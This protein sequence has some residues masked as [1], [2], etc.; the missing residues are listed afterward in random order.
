MEPHAGVLKNPGLSPAISPTACPPITGPQDLLGEV[1]DGVRPKCEVRGPLAFHSPWG[2]QVDGGMV[3]VYAVMRGHCLLDIDHRKFPVDLVSGDL[4]LVA[5]QHAHRLYDRIT[6]PVIPFEQAVNQAGMTEPGLPNLNGNS[7]LLLSM[8]FFYDPLHSHPVVSWLPPVI[9]LKGE[10]GDLPSCLGDVLRAILHEVSAPRPGTQTIVNQLA[11]VLFVQ[12]LRTCVSSLA[13]N[14]NNGL[15]ALLDPEIG[16]ALRLMHQ[17]P[18]RP[19][20]VATIAEEVGM[21]RSVF[22]ARFHA[23]VGRPPLH[24]L[25]QYRMKQ[26]CRLL[27]DPQK[28]L[29]EIAARIGYGSEAAFSNAFKRWAGTAPG[30]Y[31]FSQR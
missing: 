31:R 23:L 12:I 18:G 6:S 22:A 2:I 17:H 26:A 7:T 19:W 4:V 11:Q 1:L 29:K 27:R 30:M 13:D 25:L 10:S 8:G 20:T 14:L 9:H 16:R 3:R 28:G 15:P 21:S 24:Y 5:S